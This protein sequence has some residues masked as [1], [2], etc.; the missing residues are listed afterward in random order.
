MNDDHIEI[1]LTPEQ[2]AELTRKAAE[3]HLTP[4]EYASRLLAEI[5]F[6][7]QYRI[8]EALPPLTSEEQRAAFVRQQTEKAESKMPRWPG[9]TR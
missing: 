6:A 9:D 7:A 8:A 4:E 1:N 5:V 3:F 2:L